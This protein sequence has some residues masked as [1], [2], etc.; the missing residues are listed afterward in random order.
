MKEYMR[1]KFFAGR[2]V[3]YSV[4]PRYTPGSPAMVSE[5]IARQ[6]AAEEKEAYPYYLQGT[7]GEAQKKRAELL[8][9]DNI[10]Y[11]Y[12]ESGKLF[13]VWDLI[14]DAHTKRPNNAETYRKLGYVSFLELVHDE[15]A[16]T[17]INVTGN[18]GDWDRFYYKM[19]ERS[20]IYKRYVPEAVSM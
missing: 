1:E 19:D 6:V 2:N 16:V 18:I 17:T 10:A 12:S 7:C 9:L 13:L 11:A 3:R 5:Q 15:R 4:A 8:G 14:T 20:G